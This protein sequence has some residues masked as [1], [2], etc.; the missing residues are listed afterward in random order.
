VNWWARLWR[1]KRLEEQ[2]EK[3]LRFHLE[4]HTSDLMGRGKTPQEAER[5]ARLAL[6][7]FEQ[8]RENCRDARGTRWVE[9]LLQDS[10]YAVRTFRR[11][12]GFTA[13][14]VVI[15]ALG[16]G[17]VTAMFAVINSVLLEPLS[18]PDPGKLVTLHGLAHNF[19]EYWGFSDP[20]FLDLKQESQLVALGAW[21]YDGGTISKPGE[22]EVVDGRLVSADLF[23]I[24]GVVPVYGRNFRS[25][26]DRAGAAPV[27]IIS[28]ALW[29][30]R[31]SGDR[32]VIGKTFI[33]E[34]KPYTII[35]VLP[36]AFAV[37]GF[38]LSGDV[39]VYTP[40][41]QSTD[42]RMQYRGANFIHV[43]GRLRPGFTVAEAQAE[44]ALLGH[45]LA[46]QYPQFN[47][48]VEIRAHPLLQELVGDVRGTLW[49]LLA[50]VGL[51]LLIACVNVASLLLTRAV[52]REREVAMRVAL[53]AGWGRLARQCMTESAILGLSG[54]VLGV[55]LAAISVHPF[56]AFWPGSLPRAGE[57]H[58]EWP[59]VWFAAGIS[60]LSSLLFGLA[61]AL[62]FPAYRLEQGLRASGRSVTGRS[63]RLHGPFVIAEIALALVLLVSAG[64][65]GRALLIFSARDPGVKVENVLTAR[66]AI[67]PGALA[68][69]EQIQSAWRDVLDRGR[70][71][72]EVESIALADIVPMREGENSLRYW[73]TAA[74]PPPNQEPLT[75]A[76][77]VTPDY[78]KVMGIPLQQGRFFDEHDRIG[79]DPVVVVDENLAR[80]AFGSKDVVGKRLWIP[81]MG[82]APVQIVG[83]VGHVRHWGLAGDDLSRVPDQL[84]YPFAQVPNKLLHFFSSVMSIVVRTRVAPLQAVEPLREALRGA[85]G[86]QALYG[87]HTMEQLVYASLGRQR[88]LL[89]LFGVF[90][91]FALLLACIGIYGVLA[92]LTGQRVPEIGVRMAVGA[93]GGD[94]L[95]MVLGQSFRM[96]LGGICLGVVASLGAGG[97]LQRLVAGMQ[98]VNGATFLLM[99]PLLVLAALLAS[100][101]PARRASRVDPLKALRE[102]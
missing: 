79:S 86:D 78:L 96:I 102:E 31:F 72:P 94:I 82:S 75:L 35:G 8:V 92:Y 74:Q 99:I 17:A 5:Q 50:A 67:S 26:E 60:V 39:D 91:G 55:F 49:L 84:Y 21:T 73:T 14:T 93:S 43:V 98:P 38:E 63:H 69:P 83:V 89:L 48:G 16:I 90:A 11:K 27:A 15:L 4:E 28:H 59:V 77:S 65:L 3:E 57:I 101:A 13:T 66:F 71:L 29:Q 95:Q 41:G 52:S 2:L 37:S 9:D 47:A 58:L 22:P 100:F 56:V 46:R 97:V 1:R 76:S 36:G 87:V 30:R 18:F 19:G 62:R 40:L 34:A 61:P 88:F 54:C 68:N 23:P 70:R 45:H 24:L 53:G 32:S 33:F 64:M 51:V 44:M 7:G 81:A 6:G 85:T 10:R 42:Q 20:N 80:H 12:P 25:E